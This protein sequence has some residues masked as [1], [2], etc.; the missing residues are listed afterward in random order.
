MCQLPGPTAYSAS[1]PSPYTHRS[2]TRT[3]FYRQ[4]SLFQRL[5]PEAKLGVKSHVATP[6]VTQNLS[7]PVRTPAP[8]PNCT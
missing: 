6:S 2:H 1:H 3:H 4:L 7:H 5:R 8:S